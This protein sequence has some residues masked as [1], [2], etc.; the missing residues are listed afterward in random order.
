MEFEIPGSEENEPEA[1]QEEEAPAEEAP[2][3][4]AEPAPESE[5]DR[6]A[7]LEQSHAEVVAYL[8]AISEERQREPAQKPAEPARTK[9]NFGENTVA[10]ALW[11]R[12]E[13][14]DRKFDDWKRQQDEEKRA[15]IAIQSQFAELETKSAQYIEEQAGKGLPKVSQDDLKRKLL[16]MGQLGNRR[17][18]IEKAVQDAYRAVAWDA[19]LEATKNRAVND[20]RKPDARV[21]SR[22][23]PAA[24]QQTRRTA[25]ATPQK[26]GNKVRNATL[27]PEQVAEALEELGGGF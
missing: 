16:D 24:T 10:A 9:P 17:I 19:A 7:R 4:P 27:S 3:E 20:M 5:A 12:I 22:F 26:N 11:D 15:A 18:P 23:T 13:E 1:P 2:E 8:R 25:P 14:S 6:V 21:P